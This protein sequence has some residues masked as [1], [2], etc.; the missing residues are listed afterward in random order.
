MNLDP[1]LKPRSIAVVGASEKEN[2]V[3]KALFSNVLAGGFHGRL[4]P[5]NNKAQTVLGFKAYSSVKEIEDSVDLAIIAVPAAAVPSVLEDCGS[6]GVHA[7][8]ILSAGYK[9]S[10]SEGHARE[11][12]LIEIA[13]KHS[14]SLLGPNCL[15]L[16]NTHPD[17]KLNA[18]FAK[19]VPKPG[20]ISFLSQSG[21]L[22]VYALEFAAANDIGMARFVSLGNKAVLNENDILENFGNDPETRVILAYLED[23][24]SPGNF[25][26]QAARIASQI[27]PKPVVLIKA[28]TGQSGQRAATSHT[29][30]L[31]EKTE[32]LNDLCE[33]YGVLRVSTLEEMFDIAL[34]LSH[35]PLPAGPRLAILTNAGGPSILAADE[36]ERQGLVL[37]EPSAALRT[38]LAALL[39]Q[40]AGLKNP[41]DVLGDA[42][43]QRYGDTLKILLD[44]GEVDAVITICTPQMM[45]AMESI[46]QV[47]A[48]HAPMAREKGIPLLAAFAHFGA[49][50]EVERILKEAG[51][52]D[53]GFAENAVRA[54]AAARRHA[55]W[56]SRSRGEALKDELNLEPVREI[57]N[58]AKLTGQHALNASDCQAVLKALRFPVADSILVHSREELVQAAAMP[59][60]LILKIESPDILHKFEA[61][62]VIPGI[63]D[64]NE[65]EMSYDRLMAQVLK[66]RPEARIDGVLVQEMIADGLETIMG[67]SRHPHIGPL[68]LF[69]L[70]GTFVEAIRDV[71]FRRAPLNAVDAD[72][73]IQGLRAAALLGPF[74]NRPARDVEALRDGLLK[75]SLLM[76]EF[77][78]I[79]EMDLNPVFALEHGMK[80]ADIRIVLE[81][82]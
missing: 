71:Q 4:Y 75:L 37:P 59:F 72:D 60:P 64:M 6:K 76:I 11:E 74:R 42:D 62:G 1:L 61:G 78:E 43:P 13:R 77:P 10:G 56:R 57:L 51:I 55:R 29:G 50:S 12:A 24:Q 65:L 23:L 20:N 47:F 32:F 40:A 44:S 70:G 68:I 41:I 49:N 52:P 17:V 25:L 67:A 53:Y 45:T 54:L 73:M 5:V 81:A 14:I 19:R 36:A 27:D 80:S 16:I 39:P 58:K 7:A 15:G 21:A 34:C 26:E 18:T 28:G 69:G 33:Q 8:V 9:E 3:G 66:A 46:A 48:N 79:S 22:G 35:Q 31:A 2:S 30:A 63:R 82:S 38:R